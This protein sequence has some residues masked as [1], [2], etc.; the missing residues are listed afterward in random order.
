MAGPLVEELFFFAASLRSVPK[1]AFEELWATWIVGGG[2]KDLENDIPFLKMPYS[3]GMDCFLSCL[4]TL[5]FC[6]NI[7]SPLLVS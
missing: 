3:H 6:A 7:L 5:K 2:C 1:L 4:F